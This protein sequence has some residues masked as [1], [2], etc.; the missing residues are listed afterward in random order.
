M[1]RVNL[2]VGVVIPYYQRENGILTRC[3]QS[4][5]AQS[6]SGEISVVIVD[7][8]SPLPAETETKHLELPPNIKITV[9]KQRNAGPG[10]ARNTGIDYLVDLK[11]DC[12]ALLDSDDIWEPCHIDRA[13]TAFLL[14]ADIYS[15]SWMLTSGDTDALKDRGVTKSQLDA[16]PQLE[17]GGFLTISL[18]EQECL[19][20]TIKLS[21]FVATTTFLGNTRFDS[22]LRYASED[23]LFILTLAVRE[24]KVFISLIPEV[25]AGRG[26]NIYES[27]SYGTLDNFKTLGDKLSGRIRMKKLLTRTNKDLAHS[28]DSQIERTQRACALNLYSC[29]RKGQLSS[30]FLFIK[31]AAKNP[32]VFIY[33]ITTPLNRIFNF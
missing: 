9:I 12:I 7:D 16:S 11:V 30:I 21:A 6:Y 2:T 24:P 19:T 3:L 18:V 22:K 1:D 31:I 10:I 8:S 25:S 32:V 13:V 29:L 26:V 5:I 33:L 27:V 17:Q 4:I 14:G 20:S 23:R 28:F 15:S